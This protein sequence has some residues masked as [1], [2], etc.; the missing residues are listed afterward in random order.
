MQQA[1]HKWYGPFAAAIAAAAPWT[2]LALAG[3][4]S[5]SEQQIY[6]DEHRELPPY[7][8]P[9][10]LPEPGRDGADNASETTAS[11]HRK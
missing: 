7:T 8:V 10:I 2:L 9:A 3:C 5:G 6:R 4:A 11:L 1:S